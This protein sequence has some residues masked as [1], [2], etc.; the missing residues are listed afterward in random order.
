MGKAIERIFLPLMRLQLPEVRDIAMPRRG[1][2]PQPD[3]GL[4]PQVAIRGTRAR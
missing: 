1:R 2:L 3:S 4:D